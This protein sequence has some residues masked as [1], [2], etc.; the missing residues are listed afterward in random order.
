MIRKDWYG[1]RLSI[2]NEWVIAA[3]RRP[4][5]SVVIVASVLSVLYWAVFAS[6]RYVSEAH[7][8]VQNSDLNS[9]QS[10]DIG[11]LLGGMS[12]TNKDQL[13]LRDYLLSADMLQVLDD[14]LHLREHYSGR[15]WDVFSRL[16]SA[17]VSLEA[18]HSYYLSRINVDYDSTSGL[19]FVK[20]Q[21]FTPKMAHSIARL[22]VEEGQK[23][24]N[25]IAHRLAQEQV[26]FLEKQVR[27]LQQKDAEARQAVIRFQNEHGL[28]SPQGT[29]ENIAAIINGLEAR[30]S[31]LSTQRDA[32]L[33]Y[34][35]PNSAK[36]VELDHQIAAVK[37]QI[38]RE[39]RR[40]VA[41]EGKT[42]NETVEAFKRLQLKAE[43][44]QEVYKTA[45]SALVKGRIDAARTLKM[46][47]VLQ[48]P[49]LPQYAL[50]PE[51]MHNA[52]LSIMIILLLAGIF[53]L[54]VMII[55]DHKD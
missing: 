28:V 25:R 36:V 39:R 47:S 5:W 9:G 46:V 43:F 23:K 37:K 6:D 32:L 55:R 48:A 3:R 21:A 52:L 42:L 30:L 49:T 45:L 18:L 24:M 13:M 2:L 26:N 50:M 34:M 10:V 7:I 38:K 40:L 20:A 35:T 54:M 8:V 51:R 1:A 15:S 16:W 12:D 17:D 53:Q 41:P 22:L 33:S 11:G 19:L 27:E 31:E 44:T 14:K 29:V 4:I